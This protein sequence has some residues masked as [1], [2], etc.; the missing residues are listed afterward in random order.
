MA[1]DHQAPDKSIVL[2]EEHDE[3]ARQVLVRVLNGMGATELSR[4]T[5]VGGSQDLVS[6]EV[7][8]HGRPLVVET[9]TF[10]GLSIRGPTELVDAIAAQFRQHVNRS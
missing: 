1:S 2:A 5:G 4:L 10:I 6:V 7:L 3:E 9:E 8:I